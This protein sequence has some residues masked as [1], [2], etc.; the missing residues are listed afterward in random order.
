MWDTGRPLQPDAARRRI[1]NILEHGDF[2]FTPHA[3]AEM[4]NDRMT[5]ADCVNV[6]RAGYPDPPEWTNGAWRYRVRTPR[7]MCIVVEIQSEVELVV[8][9]AWRGNRDLR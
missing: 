6:L 9:T 5:T 7:G 2:A 1:R 3:L 8:V 4:G